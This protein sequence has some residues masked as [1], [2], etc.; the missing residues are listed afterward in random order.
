[1]ILLEAR[2]VQQNHLNYLKNSVLEGH[3]LLCKWKTKNSELRNLITHNNPGNEDTVDKAEKIL[4][5]P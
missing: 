3:F 1:M 2:K 5:I 4:G